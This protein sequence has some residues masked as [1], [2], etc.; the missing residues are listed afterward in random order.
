[1]QAIKW[2]QVTGSAFSLCGTWGW[3]RALASPSCSSLVPRALPEPLAESGGVES[4]LWALAPALAHPV[5]HSW[6]ALQLV[7]SC[8]ESLCLEEWAFSVLPALTL[9][10]MCKNFISFWFSTLQK[11]SPNVCVSF[12]ELKK[13]QLLMKYGGKEDIAMI[14]GF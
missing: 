1:M 3:Q 2:A 13:N 8:M 9:F 14:Q 12:P 6:A 11:N 5:W 10:Y 4:S 7:P